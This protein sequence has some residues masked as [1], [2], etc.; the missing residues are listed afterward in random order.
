MTEATV[1]IVKNHEWHIST[2]KK[3]DEIEM[4]D[5][6]LDLFDAIRNAIRLVVLVDFD[7][8]HVPTIAY[9]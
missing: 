7:V 2:K 5:Q 9:R 8:F 4:K 1:S 6:N 3:K